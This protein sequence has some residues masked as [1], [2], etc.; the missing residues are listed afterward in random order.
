MINIAN[1]N[2]SS[3]LD[4]RTNSEIVWLMGGSDLRVHT[5]RQPQGRQTFYKESNAIYCE[6]N[7]LPSVPLWIDTIT[8]PINQST[9]EQAIKTNETEDIQQNKPGQIVSAQQNSD[10]NDRKKKDRKGRTERR[11][12]DKGAK[13]EDN[14]DNRKTAKEARAGI[15]SNK[16]TRKRI[17]FEPEFV[18]YTAIAMEDGT[19][20][21]YETQYSTLH[22][23]GQITRKWSNRFDCP[24]LCCRFLRG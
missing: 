18:R 2:L 6:L 13:K 20:M 11:R 10:G 3:R 9:N 7:N 5:F 4:T 16:E 22:L 15:D 1:S 24:V 8:L 17:F 19:I 14:R 23:Q 21:L 12:K